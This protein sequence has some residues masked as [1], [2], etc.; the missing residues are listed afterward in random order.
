MGYA[1]QEVAGMTLRQMGYEVATPE[2]DDD[3]KMSGHLDYEITGLDLG[4]EWYV[5]DIKLRNV[6]GLK[7]LV[8]DGPDPEMQYQQ[9]VYLARRQREHGLVLV[10]PH[11]LSTWRTETKRSKLTEAVP[12][13]LVY[14]LWITAD[15]A[16][17]QR[18]RDRA[19]GLL[20]ARELGLLVN[21]EFDPNR[22]NF[23]CNYC[24][25]KTH[26]LQDDMD[27]DM[28][29]DRLFIIPGVDVSE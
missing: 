12:E 26:C 11:D 25:T 2:L 20:T 16:I 8:K 5:V 27:I 6:F 15:A 14:R 18:A 21:R 9:Q 10:L 3:D 22:D 4:S 23:P 24:D 28:D 29:N 13:P 17:Q 19:Q 1:G 7:M